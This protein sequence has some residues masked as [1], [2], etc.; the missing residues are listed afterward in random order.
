[1]RIMTY[2][3]SDLLTKA[4]RQILTTSPHDS[5]TVVD[6][7][8]PVYGIT[9]DVL[10]VDISTLT[11]DLLTQHPL[12]TALLVDDTH[13]EPE[14]LRATLFHYRIHG[15]LAPHAGVRQVW[16]DNG[17]VKVLRCDPEV[18]CNRDKRRTIRSGGCKG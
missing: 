12:T 13:I 11:H 8:Y 4:V 15:V 16:I 2:F 18:P 7:R 14:K 9:P 6:G 1:M 3:E 10:L 5:L 17:S